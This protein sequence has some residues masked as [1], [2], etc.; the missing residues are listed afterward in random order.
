MTTVLGLSA[1][2]RLSRLQEASTYQRLVFVMTIV[3]K[4]TSNWFVPL[5]TL[6]ICMTDLL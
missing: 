5:K 2:N 6:I 1:T 4:D 3:D